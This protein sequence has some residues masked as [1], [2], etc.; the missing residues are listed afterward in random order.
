MQKNKKKTSLGK[1]ET[2]EGGTFVLLGGGWRYVANFMHRPP[3]KRQENKAIDLRKE[4][5]SMPIC[6]CAASERTEGSSSKTIQLCQFPIRYRYY[7]VCLRKQG[8]A[9]I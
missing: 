4:A 3:T 8:H 6:R 1:L 2:A 7:F 5:P 9:I